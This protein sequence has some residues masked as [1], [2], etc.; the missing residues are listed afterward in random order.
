MPVCDSVTMG[1]CRICGLIVSVIVNVPLVALILS[2]S[3]GT[4][5]LKLFA[6][7]FAVSPVASLVLACTP[8]G[9]WFARA[10]LLLLFLS[11]VVKGVG[12]VIA[13]LG[14]AATSDSGTPLGGLGTLVYAIVLGVFLLSATSDLL[15]FC[16]E[17]YRTARPLRGSR[18]SVFEPL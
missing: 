16:I 2:L 6:I 9:S 3:N 10:A 1:A 7:P 14:V 13:G 12:A 17:I 18:L 4:W 15:L 11:A 8:R 5:Q